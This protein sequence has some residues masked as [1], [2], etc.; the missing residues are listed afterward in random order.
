MGA[1]GRLVEI[2]PGIDRA[3]VV[4]RQP[5]RR[6]HPPRLNTTVTVWSGSI[7]G[8]C[9]VQ[10]LMRALCRSFDRGR[11]QTVIGKPVSSG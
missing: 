7:R 9:T 6:D 10:T 2:D 1:D 4:S 3:R 11:T 5:A 8:P